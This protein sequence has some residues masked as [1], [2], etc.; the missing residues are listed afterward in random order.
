MRL[1]K[2]Y[3]Y[4]YLKKS[5]FICNKTF[6]VNMQLLLN[7]DK[8]SFISTTIYSFLYP[9]TRTV[10]HSTMDFRTLAIVHA[11]LVSWSL[12][13]Q[14]AS[15]S[16][17]LFPMWSLRRFPP[18]GGFRIW[19]RSLLFLLPFPPFSAAQRDSLGGRRRPKIGMGSKQEEER[20]GI[21]VTGLSVGKKFLSHLLRDLHFL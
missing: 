17:V 18:R 9:G 6:F 13:P 11:A 21:Q 15:S 8:Y 10:N 2:K 7:F 5:F 12:S 19:D 4:M 20:D 3:L 16:L 14:S 1:A